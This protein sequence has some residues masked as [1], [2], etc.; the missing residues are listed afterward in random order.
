M[1]TSKYIGKNNKEKVC[2]SNKSRLK[3]YLLGRSDSHIAKAEGV[4]V[5][6]II[7]WRDK[8]SFPPN[9]PHLDERMKL[10]K[11]GLSDSEIA[12]RQSVSVSCINSWRHDNELLQNKKKP[13]T[14]ISIEELHKRFRLLH[15]HGY[16]DKEIAKRWHV[17]EYKVVEWRVKAGLPEGI[18]NE[19]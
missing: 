15:S 2:E 10:Y 17:R 12:L 7:K 3:L 13:K 8:F 19:N 18:K 1:P 9:K 6:T 14:E 5:A 4:K 16:T 11:K